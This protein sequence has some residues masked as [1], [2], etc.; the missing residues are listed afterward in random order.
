MRPDEIIY[1]MMLAG[2]ALIV[3]VILCFVLRKRKLIL[4]FSSLAIIACY[5]SYFL[6]YPSIEERKHTQARAHLDAYLAEHFPDL[7]FNIYPESYT[8]G[9]TR[10]GQFIVNIANDK[11][12]TVSLAVNS[13]GEIRKFAY[14]HPVDGLLQQHDW[15]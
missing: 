1:F 8:L 14:S 13:K 2:L 5:I 9:E 4:L 12:S 7:Q 10:T 6:L 11:H 3:I 15:K